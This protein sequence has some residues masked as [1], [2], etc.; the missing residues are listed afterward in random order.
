MKQRLFIISYYQKL[1]FIIRAMFRLASSLTRADGHTVVRT[2]RV[3]LAAV[4]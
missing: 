1:L 4:S 2:G 3:T